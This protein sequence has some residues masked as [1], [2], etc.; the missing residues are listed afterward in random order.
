MGQTSSKAGPTGGVGSTTVVAP[1]IDI[2]TDDGFTDA[3]RLHLQRFIVYAEGSV[4]ELQR[5]VAEKLANEAVKPARQIQIV[6]LGGLKLL[7]PLTMSDDVEIQ[8]LAAHALANLSVLAENQ[9]KMAREGLFD[10]VAYARTHRCCSLRF[11]WTASN[12]AQISFANLPVV[13]FTATGLLN[14][15][16]GTRTALN[17]PRLSAGSLCLICVLVDAG[18]LPM[19]IRLLQSP[20]EL[21]QRQAAKGKRRRKP[22][23]KCVNCAVVD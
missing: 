9:V 1:D 19:L 7:L 12:G 10:S 18:G 2:A 16:G 14:G 15:G 11:C 22:G 4:P 17:A 20:S 21:V 8:R 13:C 23:D 6:E 3:L 5:E